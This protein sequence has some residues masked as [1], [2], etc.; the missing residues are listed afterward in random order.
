MTDQLVTDIT[1]TPPQ[2]VHPPVTEPAIFIESVTEAETV[3]LS[4]HG[5]NT[6]YTVTAA[7]CACRARIERGS[8]RWLP[9]WVGVSETAPCASHSATTLAAASCAAY[10]V[11]SR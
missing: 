11:L 10:A 6:Y 1:V 7:G 3:Y 4:P 5:S 8:R 2:Y 9:G